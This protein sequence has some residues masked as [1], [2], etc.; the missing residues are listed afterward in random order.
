[1]QKSP[2]GTPLDHSLEIFEA[3]TDII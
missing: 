2:L 3:V 1:V